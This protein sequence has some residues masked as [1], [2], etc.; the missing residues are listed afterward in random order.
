MWQYL[1]AYELANRSDSEAFLLEGLRLLKGRVLMD[2]MW[3]VMADE[4]ADY[5]LDRLRSHLSSQDRLLVSELAEGAA[6]YNVKSLV[7]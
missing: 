5:V 6:S 4:G 1:V 7:S 2:K 3:L